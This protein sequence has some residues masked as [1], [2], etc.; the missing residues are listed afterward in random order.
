[1]V[2]WLS[3]PLVI[4]TSMTLALVGAELGWAAVGGGVGLVVGTRASAVGDCRLDPG[5]RRPG[6]GYLLAL[7]LAAIVHIVAREVGVS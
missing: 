5:R 7:L 4:P 3:W 6:S 2:V 1:M